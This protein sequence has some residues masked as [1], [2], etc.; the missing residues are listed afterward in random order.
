MMNCFT[1][2][3]AYDGS[4]GASDSMSG[5]AESFTII[6]SNA[7]AG[8]FVREERFLRVKKTRKKKKKEE[9]EEEEKFNIFPCVL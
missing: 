1:K 5:C 8:F 6:S 4:A 7:I 3:Y 2:G 9:E